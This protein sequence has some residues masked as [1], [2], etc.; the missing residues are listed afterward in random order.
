MIINTRKL[1]TAIATSAI[2]MN[3][4]A[5]AFA[6]AETT[7]Q[8]TGNGSYSDNNA[9]VEQRS[10]TT[11]V[12][13]NDA[14]VSNKV[15]GT[16]STGGNDANDNT[17]G[18]TAIKTGS[19][20]SNATVSNTLNS[21][22]ADVLNCNCDKDT[23]VLI[24]GNGSHSDNDVKL[25]NSNTTGVFQ[26][27]NA[28]VY[29]NVDTTA[30]TGDNDANRNT[31]GDTTIITGNAKS[32]A[33]V[34]TVANANQASVGGNGKGEGG[35]LQAIVSGNGSYSDNDIDLTFDRY[36]TL[37][38]DNYANVYNWVDASAKTGYNDANDNT[39]GDVAIKTG[40]AYAVANVDNLV[41]FNTANLDCG[42]LTN[43]KVK[44]DG[45]GYDSDNDVK[46]H[47][48]DNKALFQDNYD[49]TDN[50]VDASAKTGDNDT[51]RNTGRVDNSNDPV[52]TITGDAKSDQNVDN[53][54]NANVIGS[55]S[56]FHM[57]KMNVD[58]NFDLSWFWTWLNASSHTSS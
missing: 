14:H 49:W 33:T 58:V 55:G 41:N 16:A 35:S 27:N 7:I 3:A 44:V 28:D 25:K 20:Q 17:G 24:S 48:N 2:L 11:V 34:S 6:F 18:N 56:G 4:M 43:T 1:V 42:C 51:N 23:K 10:D 45:N 32:N 26:T 8:V 38:Q 13:S 15:S 53:T 12:Q 57:P 22:S 29:N 52:V 39:G 19:A 47:F 30:K 37:K 21:N 9:K 5:P 46:A 50:W 36:T 31:G 54:G 40:K